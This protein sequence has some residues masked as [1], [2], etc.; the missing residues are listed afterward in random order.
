MI[1][2]LNESV[3]PSI[4]H[5]SPQKMASKIDAIVESVIYDCNSILEELKILDR[6]MYELEIVIS[7]GKMEEIKN[8]FI[9][10]L[11]EICKKIYDLI[12]SGV[13]LIVNKL[14]DKR[15]FIVEGN[16]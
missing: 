11:K 1:Y 8:K 10:K 16:R 7:E 14:N 2:Q 9:N 4:I 5:F 6:P 12:D 3:I 15:N 13:T